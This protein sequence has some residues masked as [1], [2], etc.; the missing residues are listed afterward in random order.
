MRMPQTRRLA[1]KHRASLLHKQ[2]H[3]R[4]RPL[5]GCLDTFRLAS[6]NPSASAGQ[7]RV[8]DPARHIAYAG[9]QTDC[10]DLIGRRAPASGAPPRR[11]AAARH[12]ALSRHHGPRPPPPWN[13]SAGPWAN[14]AYPSTR[15]PVPA[16]AAAASCAPPAPSWTTA[17][18]EVSFVG[19]SLGGLIARAAMAQAAQDGWRPGRLVLIGSPIAGLRHG[20]ARYVT[21]PATRRYCGECGISLTQSRE[22]TGLACTRRGR[23]RRRHGRK[24]LQPAVDRRQRFSREVTL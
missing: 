18:A 10:L 22:S 14:L 23:D 1:M 19:H 4:L 24:R 13:K 3:P 11:G 16:H 7:A 6:A 12:P 5:V 21:C 8:L 17:P 2:L 20:P 9:T 15:L